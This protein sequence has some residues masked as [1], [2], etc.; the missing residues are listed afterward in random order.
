MIEAMFDNPP[1][2][3]L[4][5]AP[6]AE[7]VAFFN[8]N[9][10]L[11]VE[12]ITTDE[13]IEWLAELYRHIFDGDGPIDR[14]GL[15]DPESAGKL[16]QYFHP[17]VQFPALLATAYV[18]NAKRYAAALLDVDVDDLTIWSH[19]IRKAPSGPAV[20]PHQDEAFWPP[21]YDYRN[22]AVW[23]P[24]HDVTVEIG[25]M[26]FIPGSHR[27]GVLKHR[28]YDHPSQNLLQ[29]DEELPETSF[30]A[31]P[32]ARGG[33]TFHH[34]ATVHRTE[35]NRSERPRLAWPMTVQTVPVRRSSR[36]SSPWL[37]EFVEAIGGHEQKT[38]AA[39]GQVLPLPA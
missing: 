14:S 23:L 13:E 22:I 38:Y 4:E 31:C 29:V 6:S 36:R 20:P 37:D 27:S 16:T 8:D 34:P 25:A 21:D 24:L 28:H 10:Y 17:E 5:V 32:L 35:S 33:C 1:A 9:G 15:R 30:V 2:V 39:D 11:T 3:H 7:E 19:M 26:Q 18:A 12:R